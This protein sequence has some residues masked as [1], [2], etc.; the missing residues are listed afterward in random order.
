[1]AEA[2]AWLQSETG[3]VWTARDVLRA[4][5]DAAPKGADVPVAFNVCEGQDPLIAQ[6][7]D[8]A[9]PQEKTSFSLGPGAM[10]T[11]PAR[12]ADD[13]LASGSA[14]VAGCGLHGDDGRYRVALD[15]GHVVRFDALRVTEGALLAFLARTEAPAA[16]AR[17]E[18]SAGPAP[19]STGDM[20]S[21]LAGIEERTEAGW[22]K[23]VLGDCPGWLA[24]ARVSRGAPGRAAATWN[25]VSV[26]L[27]LQARKVPA[28][29]LN[30]IFMHPLAAQWAGEWAR[31]N[32]AAADYGI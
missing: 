20:A 28:A 19:L 18:E 23:N 15:P 26:A 5:V 24:G 4:L 25:P 2:A 13:I 9:N 16:E 11:L 30:A 6:G 14:L 12:Y 1:M 21:L 10:A 32:Q 27:A 29:K 22:Q 31:A 17:V 3:K 8:N 7:F